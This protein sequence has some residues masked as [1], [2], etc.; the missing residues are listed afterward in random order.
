MQ[1][2]RNKFVPNAIRADRLFPTMVQL[3]AQRGLLPKGA[4]LGVVVEDCAWGNRIY[5]NKLVP[6]E[7]QLGVELVK[8]THRCIQNL[9]SDLGPVTNDIQ[10]ETLRFASSGVTHVTF[11]SFGEAFV[12]SRFTNQAHDQNYYPKYFITSNAYPWNDTR[13]GTINHAGDARPNMTGY[14]FM[15]LMDVGPLARPET[16]GQKEVQDRCHTADPKEGIY[17][18]KGKQGDEGYWFS[19]NGIR[20]YCDAF[21]VLKGVLETNGVRFSLGDFTRGYQSAL[22][23]KLSSTINAGG[24]FRVPKDGLDGVGLLRPFAWKG[25]T[26]KRGQFVYTGPSVPVP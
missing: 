18:E 22:G 21:F 10:R 16:P 4:K 5:D 15:P 8:G 26:D 19:L 3:S 9:V 14:G 6:L 25:P 12:V 24:Y 13:D 11:V 23:G 20:G 7:K 1:R 2:L 17:A